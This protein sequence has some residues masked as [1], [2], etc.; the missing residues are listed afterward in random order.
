VFDAM[1]QKAMRLSGA[2]FGQLGI[3]DGERLQ[4]PAQRSVPTAYIE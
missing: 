1:L 4:T 3:Y 2:A